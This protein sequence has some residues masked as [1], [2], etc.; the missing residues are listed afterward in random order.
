[1]DNASK[2]SVRYILFHMHFVDILPFLFPDSDMDLISEEDLKL[3]GGSSALKVRP[4]QLRTSGSP[5]VV[6]KGVAA[7]A[8]AP[9]P[10]PAAAVSEVLAGM[11]ARERNRAK[12]KARLGGANDLK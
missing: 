7:A 1:M 2:W 12:R 11:S 10:A 3:G 6:H 5:A 8:P 9:T 4:T